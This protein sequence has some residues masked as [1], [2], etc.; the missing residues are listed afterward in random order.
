MGVVWRIGNGE[1]VHIRGDRWLPDPHSSKVIS[2]QKNFPRNTQVCALLN[3]DGTR[4]IH[5][6]IDEEFLPHEARAI[7]S[8]PLS[9]SRATDC[10]IYFGS[11]DGN[12]TTK[13]AYRLLTEAEQRKKP[14][15]SNQ[16]SEGTFWKDLWDLDIHSKIKHFL[17]RASNE[18]LPTK[19]SLFRRQVMRTTTCD[20]CH[21]GVEDTIHALWECQAD[22]ET[23][24]EDDYCR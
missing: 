24:W 5:D 6:R 11:K 15:S 21:D 10:L 9:V 8:I 19:K 1:K 20:C 3:E 7:S 4:W 14:R 12:Y 16:S 2:P 18:S 13:S 17:W 22:R 23:W